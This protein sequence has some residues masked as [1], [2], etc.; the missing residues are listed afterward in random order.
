[1]TP[2]RHVTMPMSSTHTT[3]AFAV[4][5]P[6][7]RLPQS[8]SVASQ[9]GRVTLVEINTVRALLGLTSDGVRDLVDSGG[10]LWVWDLT[11]RDEAGR[12]ALRFLYREVAYPEGCRSM[13]EDEAIAAAI[14]AHG[15]PQVSISTL[16]FRWLLSRQQIERLLRADELT[17]VA[18]ERARMIPVR[19]A[20]ALLKRRLI[21]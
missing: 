3:T 4:P 11:S 8:P 15:F 7:A 18:G 16:E 5:R 10:L 1:M 19:S 14:G 6:P 13:S 20:A 21:K 17:S 9:F 2:S 12:R